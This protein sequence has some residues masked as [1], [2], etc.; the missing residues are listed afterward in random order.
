MFL[1]VLEQ[2]HRFAGRMYW[3]TNAEDGGYFLRKFVALTGFWFFKNNNPY[4]FIKMMMK[5]CMFF[6]KNY[7]C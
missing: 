5:Y 1:S 7:N 2:K 4:L 6:D 3:D